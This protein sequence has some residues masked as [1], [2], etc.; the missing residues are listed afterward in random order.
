MFQKYENHR[1]DSQNKTL[2][3]KFCGIFCGKKRIHKNETHKKD[4]QNETH[5]KKHEEI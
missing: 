2:K 5:K 3:I 4:S 1:K